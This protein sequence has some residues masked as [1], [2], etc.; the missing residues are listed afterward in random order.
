MAKTTRT[1]IYSSIV[2]TTDNLNIPTIL[3]K[4]I[5]MANSTT[6][7]SNANFVIKWGIQQSNVQNLSIPQKLNLLPIRH[8]PPTL[9]KSQIGCLTLV[10]LITL[11]ST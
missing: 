6:S 7:K 11:L 5:T 1:M 4:G 10:L 3:A 8:L 9:V 2:A